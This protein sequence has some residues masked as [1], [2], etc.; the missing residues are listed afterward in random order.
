MQIGSAAPAVLAAPPRYR[1]E[2]RNQAPFSPRHHRGVS[3]DPGT[4]TSLGSSPL[5]V[6]RIVT[7]IPDFLADGRAHAEEYIGVDVLLRIY[8]V[9]SGPDLASVV[10]QMAMFAT[11]AICLPRRILP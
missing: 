3:N 7:G 8:T 4:F 6:P 1:K 2:R 10:H 9:Q 11:D 5:S